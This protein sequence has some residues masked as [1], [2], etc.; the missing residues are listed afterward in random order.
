MTLLSNRTNEI[1]KVLSIIATIMLPLSLITG[2]F[3]MNFH[4]FP[5]IDYEFGVW[6]VVGAMAVLAGIML[7]YFR[8]KGWF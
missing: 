2:F 3:G 4:S 1:M 7:V 6:F 8:R 5:G